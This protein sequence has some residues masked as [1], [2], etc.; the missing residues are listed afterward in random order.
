MNEKE[1]LILD[2]LFI[3]KL[4]QT[5]YP[6]SILVQAA[7]MHNDDIKKEA[8][9]KAIPEFMQFNIVESEVKNLA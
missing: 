4:S 3:Q 8:R 7:I 9:K 1:S 5:V 2:S 6:S